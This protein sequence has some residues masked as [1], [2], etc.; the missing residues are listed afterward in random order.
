MNSRKSGR[1][2]DKER[3]KAGIFNRKNKN[4]QQSI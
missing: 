4:Y 1:Q 2:D 3:P